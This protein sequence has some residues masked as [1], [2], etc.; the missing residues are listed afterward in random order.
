MYYL[1]LK[2]REGRMHEWWS[3]QP[4]TGALVTG[5]E[6]VEGQGEGRHVGIGRRTHLMDGSWGMGGGP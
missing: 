4:H 3:T 5:G 6:V 1:K 2:S